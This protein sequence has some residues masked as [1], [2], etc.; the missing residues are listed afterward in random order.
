MQ[1]R[2]TDT[3]IRTARIVF[4]LIY[5]LALYYNLI[6]QGGAVETNFF[7]V[8]LGENNSEV[9]K[10]AMMSLGIIPIFMGAT[11]ICLFKK[12]HMRIVQG[13]FGIILF[14]LSGKI[15]EGPDLDVDS[16]VAF[17]GLF[18]LFAG[19]TGKCIT[20]NCLKYKET[21]TKIRV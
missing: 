3:T 1:K 13:S 4:G 16:L 8:E 15:V 6:I 5:I 19:I 11:N 17:M 9:I 20:S 14:Y 12:K 18:P 7:W 2:P 21:I 10:Y